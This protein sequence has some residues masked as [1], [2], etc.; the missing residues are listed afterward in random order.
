ML[1]HPETRAYVKRRTTDGKS[2]KEICRC[3]MRHVAGGIYPLLM[4]DLHHAQQ[5]S[6]LT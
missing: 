5:Q 3:P 2:T 6:A 4:A 1:H